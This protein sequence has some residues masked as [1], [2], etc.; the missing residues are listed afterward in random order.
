MK[1]NVP[2]TSMLFSMKGNCVAHLIKVVGY[3]NLAPRLLERLR[4]WKVIILIELKGLFC[5]LDIDFPMPVEM[6]SSLNIMG[7]K[8]STVTLSPYIGKMRFDSGQGRIS[9]N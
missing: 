9:H 4:L 2:V 3:G 8:M 5:L 1:C 6:Q 7:E